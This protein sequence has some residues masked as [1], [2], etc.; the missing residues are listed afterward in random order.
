MGDGRGKR[1][2][3]GTGDER[4]A[5]PA[6]AAGDPRAR[7]YG[8]AR[9]H[10]SRVRWLRRAIPLGAGLA[11][12]LVGFVTLFDPFGRLG[13]EGMSI[14][15]LNLSG[16]KITMERPRLTGFQKDTRPYEV[17]AD[18]ATQDVR[19]PTVVEL[20]TMR[21]RLTLDERG[22][23]ARLEAV[24][25]IFDTQKEQ[26]ELRENVVVTTDSGY[27]ALM[28]QAS[29]DFKAGTVV[30]R[31]PVQIDLP[32]G[33]IQADTLQVTD[34][35]QRIAFEGRVRS[36]FNPPQDAPPGSAPVRTS[37]AAPPTTRP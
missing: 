28:R 21:G 23:Q 18:Q 3:Q 10:S 22:T 32:G 30:S 7:A 19:K 20:V 17:T 31:E 4:G 15:G 35:G 9:R 8:R 6:V 37:D 27:R 14:G 24:R 34:G 13:I 2:L 1:P 12:G 29:V 33:T 25:G 26:L 5:T 11:V 16:T 36:R